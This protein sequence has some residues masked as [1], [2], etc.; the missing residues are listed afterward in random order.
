[1][2]IIFS[3]YS[4]TGLAFSWFLSDSVNHLSEMINY[5]D[6]GFST[7]HM[8]VNECCKAVKLYVQ[9]NVTQ[10]IFLTYYRKSNLSV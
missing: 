9:N 8:R 2:L 6:W 10:N 3:K 4:K 1:M 7:P 5:N